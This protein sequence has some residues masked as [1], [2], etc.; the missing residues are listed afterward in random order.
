[1]H[2]GMNS[3][4]G[5]ALTLF[6]FSL[7]MPFPEKLVLTGQSEGLI[8]AWSLVHEG[9][10]PH[11]RINPDNDHFLQLPICPYQNA[12]LPASYL[13]PLSTFNSVAI[14]FNLMFPG[15]NKQTKTKNVP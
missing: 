1:M 5:N 15:L 6:L 7:R 10:L 8:L 9:K 12:A 13:Y 14:S 2:S 11:F 3:W 4:G